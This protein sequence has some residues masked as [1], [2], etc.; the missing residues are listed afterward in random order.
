MGDKIAVFA[1]LC[2]VAAVVFGVLRYRQ[3]RANT[4][5]A[6]Q[7][8]LNAWMAE[9]SS[10]EAPAVVQDESMSETGEVVGTGEVSD[11]REDAPIEAVL[12]AEEPTPETTADETP[13]THD[14]VVEPVDVRAEM[15]AFFGGAPASGH[16]EVPPVAEDGSTNHAPGS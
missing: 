3:V 1:L 4:R 15:D 7:D 2:S 5:A 8:R 9:M 14:E 12:D 16:T 10:Y 11:A 13:S 6:A